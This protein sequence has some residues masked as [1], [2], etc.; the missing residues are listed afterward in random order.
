[1]AAYKDSRSGFREVNKSDF[2]SSKKDIND[3][4]EKYMAG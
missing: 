1:M 4:H 3:I 2:F